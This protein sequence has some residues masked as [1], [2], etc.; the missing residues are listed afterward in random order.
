MIATRRISLAAPALV[1][2]LSTA[3]CD[4]LST[5]SGERRA[6]IALTGEATGGPFGGGGYRVETDYCGCVSETLTLVD[7]RGNLTRI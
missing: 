1:L 5:D 6:P 4:G 3:A 7:G 2:A